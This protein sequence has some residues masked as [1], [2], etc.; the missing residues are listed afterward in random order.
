MDVNRQVLDQA[1][2]TLDLAPGQRFTSL[3]EAF[4]NADSDFCI[5][6]IPP[7]YNKQAVS[8]AVERGM[9]V[10]S[11]KPIADNWQSCLDI[12]HMV[13]QNGLKMA[14]TQNYR[15]TRRI[16]TLQRALEEGGL[17]AILYITARFGVDHRRNVGGRFR[18]DRPDIMLYEASVHHFDQL[19]NLSGA[20]CA[21]IAGKTWN[22][23]GSGFD[24]DCCGLFVM[25]MANG[26]KTQYET[27]YIAAGV[28]NDWHREYYRVD[29]E[30]GS[31]VVDRDN[32]V[33]VVEHLAMGRT[34]VTEVE[35][36]PSGYKGNHEEDGHLS[37]LDQFLTW[38]DG[39]PTP[40][41]EIA[42]NL[43]TAALCFAAAEASQEGKVVDVANKLQSAGVP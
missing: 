42:D 39:G 14:I 12:F 1:G 41:T 22:P 6:A 10:L 5:L 3:E 4:A 33:R 15:F 8:L 23:A 25:E 18:Y 31:V 19:R 40:Q 35:A 38:L 13:D 30:K 24:T 21:W 2:D 37:M 16:L 36:V 43:R 26:I 17:G 32:T 34:K 29:C 7:T 27:S 9:P 28:Q 11:E 20:D